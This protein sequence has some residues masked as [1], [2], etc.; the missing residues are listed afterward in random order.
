M[1]LKSSSQLKPSQKSPLSKNIM[2]PIINPKVTSPTVKREKE[3][4]NRDHAA[5][6]VQDL[7][8]KNSFPSKASLWQSRFSK[9]QL[10]DLKSR[11]EK[12][13]SYVLVDENGEVIN[14][15]RENEDNCKDGELNGDVTP[16][17]RKA[18]VSAAYKMKVP[19]GIKYKKLTTH[20]SLSPVKMEMHY[21]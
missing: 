1:S 21:I 9:K 16:R 17:L 11:F 20:T 6:A 10:S 12:I 3:K 13:T 18:P 2:Q 19:L 8:N 7:R 5:K 15:E 14:G 4:L